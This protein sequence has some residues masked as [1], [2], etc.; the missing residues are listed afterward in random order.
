MTMVMALGI[1]WAVLILELGTLCWW[2]ARHH[3]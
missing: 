1:G 2:V 3:Q